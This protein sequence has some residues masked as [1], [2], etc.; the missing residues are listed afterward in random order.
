[1]T[2][3][4]RPSGQN[5]AASEL[6]AALAACR[7]AFL[8]VALFSGMSNVLMLTGALFMLEVYDRV[9]PSRSVPTLVALLI[10]TAGLYAAQGFIEA[11]RSRILVRIGDSLD[12]AMNM[13]VYDAIVRLPLKIGA[14]GD[15]SQ[16]SRALD[17]VRGFL[18]GAGPSAFF[19]LPCLPVY[20][21]I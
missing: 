9:L 10:L 5:F 21:P 7:R 3:L 19:D 6:G 17:A 14:K 15:G 20:L 12:E 18:S 2:Q 13:R 8:A 4:P 1:M 11:I 16:T